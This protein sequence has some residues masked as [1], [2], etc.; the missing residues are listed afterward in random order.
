MQLSKEIFD[1]LSR[2]GFICSDSVNRQ[3]KLMYDAIED[4]YEQYREYYRGVGFNLE[5]GNG[6][7][8]FSRDESRVELESKLDRFTKWIDKAKNLYAEKLK[9][10][11]TVEKLLDELAKIGFI[12]LENELE[13][14][15]K[16]TSSFH[17]LEEMIDCI[18]ITEDLKNEMPE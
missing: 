11:E 13:G 12:E 14:V 4:N 3:T 15:W 7:Y 16:V 2:G 10:G 17:Y 9:I 1:I 18:T 5:S 8:Y 6:Y